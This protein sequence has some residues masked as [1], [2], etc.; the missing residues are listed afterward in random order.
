MPQR[1]YPDLPR[2]PHPGLH[3]GYPPQFPHQP[4][5]HP[6]TRFVPFVGPQMPPNRPLNGG[7]GGILD[8]TNHRQIPIQPR[9]TYQSQTFVSGLGRR[10]LAMVGIE[11]PSSS[12]DTTTTPSSVE[13]AQQRSAMDPMKALQNA[14]VLHQLNKGVQSIYGRLS[15]MYNSTVQQQI[16]LLQERFK[17]EAENSTNPWQQRMAQQ[18]PQFFKNMAA[19]VEDAQE[20]L[21][22]VW[23]QV[24]QANNGT[25]DTRS[26]QQQQ[27]QQVQGG[28]P[29][30][31]FLDPF[32]GYL[33]DD[34]G[35]F[36]PGNF[37]NQFG[38]SFGMGENDPTNID[39]SSND[40]QDKDLTR[41]LLNFWHN[42]VQPQI[43][44]IR[45]Q[46]SRIWRDLT[47]SGAFMPEQ[48]FRS[49]SSNN[50]LGAT[51]TGSGSASE[52][53]S[54]DFVDNVLS[55]IDLN[56]PEYS[57]V[58]PKGEDQQRQGPTNPMSN[59]GSQIQTRLISMQRELNQLWNG[60]TNSLQG[61]IGNVKTALNPP[62]MQFNPLDTMASND[63]KQ[64]DT[65]PAQ[66]E[67]GD[68]IKDIS[69]LQRD[70]DVVY[71]V[72]Q[73]QQ[74]RQ[75]FGDRF[76]NFFNNMD[77]SGV[78]QPLNRFSESVSRFG[79]AVG[80]FWNQIPRRWDN[81]MNNNINN[82]NRLT[83]SSSTTT[84]KNQTESAN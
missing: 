73:K 52:N 82:N 1:L 20:N 23:K 9:P 32:N 78:E 42:Q 38:R 5:N 26:Q 36:Q 28:P 53:S 51:R 17:K 80:D 2:E 43:G 55:G 27:Q 33:G 8:P 10:L 63:N 22:R 48:V 24:M 19:K 54:S 14:T 65:D 31:S 84:S 62:R 37:F 3:D 35:G 58:E 34:V 79:N 76:R 6:P 29:S 11:M 71:D 56:S 7:V 66:N 39:G 50:N 21:N 30:R 41:Q 16:N 60:L 44:M 25:I 40:R 45:G 49:R 67:I 18:V 46:V 47:S 64:S 81:F 69:K 4:P 74:Q 12:N 77:L 75:S 13:G 70:A 61:A 68:R 57:L 59:V 72:V 15:D 83:A